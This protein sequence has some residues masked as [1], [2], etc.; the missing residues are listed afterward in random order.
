MSD[1]TNKEKRE[2]LVVDLIKVWV[3]SE[4]DEIPVGKKLA[5]SLTKIMVF[6]GGYK[7]F[8]GADKKEETLAIL[9][10]LLEGTDS[11]GPDFVVDAAIMWIAEH[12][13]DAL[14]DAF[15]GKFNFDGDA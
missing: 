6:V 2:F 8:A 15:K 1:L 14:Y 9:E 3:A 5:D 10:L 13:I 7:D 4:F 11:P 12:V